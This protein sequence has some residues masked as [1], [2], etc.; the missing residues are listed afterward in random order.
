CD[1]DP[2]MERLVARLAVLRGDLG[3]RGSRQRDR[4]RRRGSGAV[5]RHVVERPGRRGEVALAG[6]RRIRGDGAG[7]GSVSF[8]GDPD[9]GHDS[10]PGVRVE[11]TRSLY[12]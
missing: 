7:D 1:A 11:V 3:L 8:E 9:G 10:P 12:P 5:A 4:I 6:A 2:L